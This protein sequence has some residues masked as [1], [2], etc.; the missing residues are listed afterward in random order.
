MHTHGREYRAYV[1]EGIYS[2]MEVL[3]DALSLIL[4]PCYELTGNWWVSILLFTIIVKIILMPLALWCQKNAIVMVQLMPDLNRLKIKYFGDAETIGEKQNELYK[5]KHYHPMLSLVPLAIQIIILFGLVDVIHTITDGG[6]PGTEFLGMIPIENGGASWVMPVLAGLSAIALGCA[7]NRIN[8][9]QKEQ[10]RAEKNTTNGLSIALSFVL[11]IFVAAGMAFYWICSNLTA[12]I[13]QVVCNI[14]INPK[15]HID[16]DDLHATASELETLNS[17][18]DRGLKWYQRDPLAKREKRDYKRFFK[19]VDKHL[20]FYSEKSGFYKYFQGAIEWLLAN[21]TVRIHYVTNDPDDRIFDLAQEC[22]RIFPY[23]I[24]EK[25]AITLMMKMDADV[26]VSTQE[27]LDNFYIKKSYLRDDVE[28]VFMF[29][30]MT[31]THLTAL[32]KSYDNFDT[33]LCA[34]PHQVEEIRAAEKLRDLPEKRL[35]EYGYD[36]LDRQIAEYTSKPHEPNEKPLV[37]IGPSWQQDNLLDLCI[38]EMLE[39]LFGKGYRI[40]VRPHPEY[41]KRYPARW[42]ALVQRY[43]DRIGDD[44]VLETDLATNESIFAA[45]VLVTDWSTISCEFSFTTL[46]P[47]MFIDTPMKVGNPKW[48]ELGIE[49]TDISLRNQIGVSLSPDDLSGFGAA[50]DDMIVNAEKWNDDIREVRDSFIFNIGHSAPVA[51][52]YILEAV[53]RQQEKR[54]G[55]GTG[56]AFVPKAETETGAKAETEE[57][58]EKAHA[59]TSRASSAATE[60]KSSASGAHAKGSARTSKGTDAKPASAKRA[61]PTRR[62]AHAKK[63]PTSSA[64]KKE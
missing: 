59:K 61:K 31:S 53:L 46:K 52:G 3:A 20:V 16:Y 40:V 34:G 10:S 37:L 45:D 17:L 22:P 7:Q 32:E 11:G 43:A 15:K 18:N 44:F 26:V 42:D 63:K 55:D 51:G 50:V 14:V 33:L 54:A 28:Y 4:K 30:H 36:L 60:A 47:T 6:A 62:A 56:K 23:Y 1:I 27:D 25:K 64:G 19:T 12:I 21:S 38:D 2:V 9:L 29:H 57:A 39:Q 13:V 49:P 8:P 24:G 41:L 58:P 48:E 5:E 35:I